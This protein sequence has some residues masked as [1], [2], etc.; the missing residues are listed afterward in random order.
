MGPLS[1]FRL[2][3]LKEIFYLCKYIVGFFDFARWLITKMVSFEAIAKCLHG[4][5]Y[6]SNIMEGKGKKD[7]FRKACKPF[8]I[9]RGQLIY[10]NS[11]LVIS[12][13]ERRQ[14]N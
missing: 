7:K 1:V 5:V 9:L 6:P 11:R 12:H 4:N 3:V 13:T 10:N 8:S 2:A 14:N